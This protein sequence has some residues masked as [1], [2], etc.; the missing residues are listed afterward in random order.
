M[1]LS[2]S[3]GSHSPSPQA[4]KRNNNRDRSNSS[5]CGR[6]N[7]NDDEDRS[8]SPEEAFHVDGN[9]AEDPVP[10]GNKPVDVKIKKSVAVDAQMAR[11]YEWAARLENENAINR[12]R[13]ANRNTN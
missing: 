13:E 1:S 10:Q 8:L 7:H 4:R 6:N 5:D 9:F 12:A 11:L 3:P 2:R